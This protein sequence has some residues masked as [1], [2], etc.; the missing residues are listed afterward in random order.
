MTTHEAPFEFSPTA[1][2]IPA[3]VFEA[4]GAASVAWEETPQG[5]FD[6]TRAKVIGEALLA[7]LDELSPRPVGHHAP[8]FG[9][10]A[11]AERLS[12]EA[13]GYTTE[14]DDEGGV[15]HLVVEAM[16][17][18]SRVGSN[19]APLDA[20]SKRRQLVKAASLLWAAADVIDRDTRL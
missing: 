3:V 18:A 8:D 17:V 2:T 9:D 4:L 10:E 5:V 12:H 11:R 6:S 1:I 7:K 13:R 14:H 20:G 19:A 16:S 15:D